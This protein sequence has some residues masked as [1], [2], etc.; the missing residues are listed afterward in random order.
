MT[1]SKCMLSPNPKRRLAVAAKF[2][3]AYT[4]PLGISLRTVPRLTPRDPAKTLVSDLLLRVT[5][6]TLTELYTIKFSPDCNRSLPLASEIAYAV[7]VGSGGFRS[8]ACCGAFLG[9]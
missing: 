3:H 7:G 9:A 2:L 4:D 5:N 6:N 8:T 1:N